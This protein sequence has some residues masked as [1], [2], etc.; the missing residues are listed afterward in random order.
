MYANQVA[1]SQAKRRKVDQ[2]LIP[3]PKTW[4]ADRVGHE[5]H[6]VSPMLKLR[7]LIVFVANL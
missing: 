1:N 6:V 2:F 4:N 5:I 3:K 7:S